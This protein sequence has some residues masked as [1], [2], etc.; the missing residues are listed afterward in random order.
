MDQLKREFKEDMFHIYREAVKIKYRPI[1]FLEMISKDD[2]IVT[3]VRQLIQKETSGF[4]RLYDLNRLDL[5]VEHYILKSKYECLF[6]EEDRAI[7]YDRLVRYG[8]LN[9]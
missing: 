6:T 3:I 2:D 9:R 7:C 4:I 1:Y 8:F 5:S